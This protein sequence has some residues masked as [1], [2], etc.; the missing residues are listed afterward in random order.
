MLENGEVNYAC[1]CFNGMLS[2]GKGGG[3]A[4]CTNGMSCLPPGALSGIPNT[5]LL[6]VL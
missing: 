3:S 1:A 2:D 4:L 6:E 5:T